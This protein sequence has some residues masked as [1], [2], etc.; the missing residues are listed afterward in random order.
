MIKYGWYETINNTVFHHRTP[1]NVAEMVEQ[2]SSYNNIL[3]EM[4]S[5]EK[6]L[7]SRL[8]AI[9]K[10]HVQNELENKKVENDGREIEKKMDENWIVPKCVPTDYFCKKYRN[11]D[12]KKESRN[13][14]RCKLLQCNEDEEMNGNENKHEEFSTRRKNKRSNNVMRC[15]T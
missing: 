14:N 5:E 8:S 10:K 6:T 15:Q 2:L 7:D 11:A 13:N 9:A 1:F 4:I 3:R 12:E